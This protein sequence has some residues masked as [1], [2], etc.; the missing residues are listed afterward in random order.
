MY[1]AACYSSIQVLSRLQKDSSI[2]MFLKQ[3]Q[4]QLN[5]MLPLGAY[6]L[7]PVQRVLKYSLLLGQLVKHMSVEDEGFTELSFALDKMTSVSKHINEMMRYDATI[8]NQG[9]QSLIRGSEDID[10]TNAGDLVLEES[11]RYGGRAAG[12]TIRGR[13]DRQVYVFLFRKLMLMTKKEDDEYQYKMH[14]EMKDIQLTERVEKDANCFQVRQVSTG[15]YFT[16]QAPSHKSKQ[17]WVK[18]IKLLL[19]ESIPG[20]PDKAKMLIMAGFPTDFSEGPRR[21]P[22]STHHRR[23]LPDDASPSSLRWDKR[24]ESKHS[25]TATS[26]LQQSKAKQRYRSNTSPSLQTDKLAEGTLVA[27]PQLEPFQEKQN[28]LAEKEVKEL[29]DLG[30]CH[31]GINEA[32]YPTKD[33]VREREQ[34]K[35]YTKYIPTV[36]V[37]PPEHLTDDGFSDSTDQTAGGAGKD[38]S[39]IFNTDCLLSPTIT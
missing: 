23:Q 24:N 34:K 16:L 5:H 26:L 37:T 7:K 8:H 35:K 10:L 33:A 36:T 27:K 15:N 19:M 18:N 30:D 17:K 14:L 31:E 6:L 22:K 21:S 4:Q 3:C 32:D 29:V 2:A 13:A 28:K 11:L 38:S 20:L 12:P 39:I 9:L 25:Q 1:I